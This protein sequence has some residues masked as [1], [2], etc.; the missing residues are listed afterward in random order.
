MELTI[1]NYK[2]T[3]VDYNIRPTYQRIKILEY[4]EGNKTHPTVDEIYNHLYPKIPTLSKTTVYNTLRSFADAN[5]VLELHVDNSEVRFDINTELHGHFLCKDCGTIYDFEINTEKLE[6]KD[7]FIGLD[8][9]TIDSKNIFFTGICNHC[10][11]K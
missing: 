3:L 7:L 9:F 5:L 10:K 8:D 6:S 1:E 11:N 2:E 4:L